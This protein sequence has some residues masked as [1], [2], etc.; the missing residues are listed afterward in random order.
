V[1]HATDGPDSFSG[2]HCV[3]RFS[4]LLTTAGSVLKI[5]PHLLW[6]LLIFRLARDI[7]NKQAG[8]GY[9]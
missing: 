1:V 7:G 8:L 9:Q 3:W 2:C 6:M 5:A 4:Y